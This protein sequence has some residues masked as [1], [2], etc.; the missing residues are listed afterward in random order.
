METVLIIRV[1]DADLK[2]RFRSNVDAMETYVKLFDALLDGDD[3][4][5]FELALQVEGAGE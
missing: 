3:G 1:G 4:H 5:G 2:A